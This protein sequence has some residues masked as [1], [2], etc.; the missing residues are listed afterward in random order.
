MKLAE[1]VYTGELNAYIKDH[2]GKFEKIETT[3]SKN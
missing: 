1:L 2:S 3:Y